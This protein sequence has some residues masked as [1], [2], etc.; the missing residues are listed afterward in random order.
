[1]I[2]KVVKF[3]DKHRLLLVLIILAV[4]VIV[5]LGVNI[6]C[7][8]F[9]QFKPRLCTENIDGV[10]CFS[11]GAK[12]FVKPEAIKKTFFKENK[13]LIKDL[14]QRFELPE[15][16]NYTA[17]YYK[18]TS[19]IYAGMTGDD[20][21]YEFFNTYSVTYDLYHFYIDYSIYFDMFYPFKIKID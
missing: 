21:L 8:K 20:K 5:F 14:V 11:K 16:N 6:L 12:V 13:E 4:V 3:L 1:M 18:V 19:E 10:Y 17:Y 2:Q 9:H 7:F 15:F